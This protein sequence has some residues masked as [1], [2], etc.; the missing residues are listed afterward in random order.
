MDADLRL[1]LAAV[2]FLLLALIATATLVFF[3]RKLTLEY[4]KS[5]SDG[6]DRHWWRFVV[7][8]LL[9]LAIA[10]WLHLGFAPWYQWLY[11]VAAAI[12][13]PMA[14]TFLLLRDVLEKK[15]ERLSMLAALLLFLNAAIYGCQWYWHFHHA[16]AE[17]IA[18]G[19]FENNHIFARNYFFIPMWVLTIIVLGAAGYVWRKENRK[20]NNELLPYYSA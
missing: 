17:S 1:A 18:Q 16:H 7:P 2:F 20:E 5:K 3:L 6:I 14:V 12:G 10:I 15:T 8:T 4:A 13:V 9:A 19:N 11:L